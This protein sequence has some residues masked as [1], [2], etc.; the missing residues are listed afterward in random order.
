M[1]LVLTEG[2][3]MALVLT[4]GY[5]MALVLTEGY[6]DTNIIMIREYYCVMYY[7]QLNYINHC[8]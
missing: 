1:A 3:V 4:E 6:G 7:H 5:V 2:F 8:A